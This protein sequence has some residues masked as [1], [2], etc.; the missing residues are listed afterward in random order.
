ML[1]LT[2]T[3][4]RGKSDHFRRILQLLDPDAFTGEGLPDIEELRAYVI[5]T[6]KRLAVDYDGK[7]LFNERETHRFDVLLDLNKH[8]KQ[9]ELYGAV[10]DYVR[11]RGLIP[12]NVLKT[13]LQD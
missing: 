8:R 10:T 7:K 12:Q 9:M 4:H 5:R 1:L 2:A 13:M 3:P 11:E 6:E